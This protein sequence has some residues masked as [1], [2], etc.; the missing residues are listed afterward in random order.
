MAE[1]ESFGYEGCTLTVETSDIDKKVT[2][3]PLAKDEK[4]I[5]TR[6]LDVTPGPGL[7]YALAVAAAGR[8]HIL[9]FGKNTKGRDY[10]TS[11]IT[12]FMPNLLAD[13]QTSVNRIFSLAGLT[14]PNQ[15][16][17]ERPFRTPHP[18]ASIEGMC[19]GGP[20]CKP[21]EVSLAHNGV[22]FLK[23][24]AEFKTSV[25]Q[26]LRVPLETGQMTLSRAGKSTTYPANLQLVMTTN[27]CPCGN[28]TSDSHVCVCSTQS[29]KQYWAK[30]SA[31]LLDKVSIRY[32]S[33]ASIIMPMFRGY[34]ELRS[35]VKSAV[36]KQMKRQGKFNQE[37]SDSEVT[38]YCKLT[39]NAQNLLDLAVARYNLS[40]K[41]KDN[42]IRLA[43]TVLDMKDGDWE[44]IGQP[45]MEQ[46]IAL[47]GKLPEQVC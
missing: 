38:K 22:L 12:Q 43:R 23:D 44:E 11:Q 40:P 21:G 19:G 35:R 34:N 45:S 7:V 16:I 25:L 6:T 30:L 46:A 17:I 8:H 26:M 24:A 4:Q 36:E 28:L 39:Y 9:V 5:D 2:F 32:C 31:P 20:K 42:I 27:P 3:A 15:K 29:I 37:L 14:K 41:V 18:T 13:E 1:N 33:D 47:Y 10:T